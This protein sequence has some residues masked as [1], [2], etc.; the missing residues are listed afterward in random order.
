VDGKENRL[1]V[2]LFDFDQDIYHQTMSV[3]F[4]E[5]IRDEL[6]FDSFDELK[7]QIEKDAARARVILSDI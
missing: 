4:V 6:K 2:H 7:V 1:E 5:K 3:R